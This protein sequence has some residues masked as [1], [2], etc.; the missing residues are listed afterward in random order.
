[1]ARGESEHV[2]GGASG[3][4]EPGSAAE[5]PSPDRVILFPKGTRLRWELPSWD[6]AAG[7]QRQITKEV[8]EQAP[9]G[10]YFAMEDRNS[11]AHPWRKIF[12]VR[13]I[14]AYC[15]YDSLGQMINE[16]SEGVTN[17]MQSVSEVVSEFEEYY[18]NPKIRHA[19]RVR[20]PVP[21]STP[22]PSVRTRPSSPNDTSTSDVLNAAL[23]AEETMTNGEAAPCS[24]GVAAVPSAE[25]ETGSTSIPHA[26]AA[27]SCLVSLVPDYGSDDNQ[28]EDTTEGDFIGG[29]EI[30]SLYYPSSGDELTEADTIFSAV[31]AMTADDAP[32]ASDAIAAPAAAPAG[33]SPADAADSAAADASPARPEMLHWTATA[34]DRVCLLSGASEKL[35]GMVAQVTADAVII[36]TDTLQW[37]EIPKAECTNRLHAEVTQVITGGAP[38]V[39]A[40]TYGAQTKSTVT[41]ALLGCDPSETA[42][43]GAMPAYMA[44][45][46]R[47]FQLTDGRTRQQTQQQS[48]AD[49]AHSFALGDIVCSVVDDSIR[50]VVGR[51]LYKPRVGTNQARKFLILLEVLDNVRGTAQK[52]APQF[53]PATWNQWRRVSSLPNGM[54]GDVNPNDVDAPVL[55]LSESNMVDLIKVCP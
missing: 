31:A 51:V 36:A 19:P 32:E 47:P 39:L 44:H 6:Y 7:A 10:S 21:S 3:V 53:F 15:I 34:G 35:G 14:D 48:R 42:F 29:H 1:M 49:A 43:D 41:G 46:V 12:A 30:S 9:Q 52:A 2:G 8:L 33:D 24:A 4:T 18:R 45:Y 20:V 13:D 28:R 25:N 37:V 54:W 40:F 26:H 27:S 22:P 5:E 17:G 23:F 11:Y 55:T 50:A 16:P 38:K